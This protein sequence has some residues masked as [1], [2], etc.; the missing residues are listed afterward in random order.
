[1]QTPSAVGRQL[2][3]CVQKGKGKTHLAWPAVEQPDPVTE[4]TDDSSSVSS[5]DDFEMPLDMDPV[6]QSIILDGHTQEMPF[7]AGQLAAIQQTVQQFVAKA[8]HSHRSQAVSD[9]VQPFHSFPSSSSGPQ[10]RR[11]GAATPLGF[12]R[13]LEESS[14]ENILLGEYIDFALL[15]HLVVKV[16]PWTGRSWT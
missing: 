14:G 4:V 7:T 10:Q 5:E 3:G 13:A 15:Q 9:T 1:M 12:Q 6:E 16:L 11:S 8:L 2:A